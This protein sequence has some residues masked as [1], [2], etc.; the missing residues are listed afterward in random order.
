VASTA[1]TIR[2]AAISGD[3]FGGGYA[4]DHAASTVLGDVSMTFDA[5]NSK[6]ITVQGGIYGGGANP[7]HP[8][9]GGSSVVEGDAT[10][11]FT[12]SGDYLA[13]STVSGDGKVAGTVLGVKTLSFADFTGDFLGSI[14]SFDVVSFSGNTVMDYSGGYAASTI[15][16]D[17]TGRTSEEAFASGGFTVGGNKLMTIEVGGHTGNCDLMALD[18]FDVLDGL[19]VEIYKNEEFL[20]SFEWGGSFENYSLVNDNGI[21]ALI[22]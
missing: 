22:S 13:V 18:D 8:S 16:F 19:T 7:S 5:S 12:G 4:Y 3:V 21:L 10:I 11:T 15:A 20:G 2:N 6:M 17:L 9:M 1:I 14:Q